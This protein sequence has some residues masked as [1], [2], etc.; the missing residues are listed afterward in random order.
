[1]ST[2]GKKVYIVEKFWG[3]E[4]ESESLG[5]FSSQEKAEARCQVFILEH[6]GPWTRDP[7]EPTDVALAQW[8]HEASE[9]FLT[10]TQYTIDKDLPCK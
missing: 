2:R 9:W 1:M 7:R 10:I 6:P 3:Y 8:S 4:G 5:V